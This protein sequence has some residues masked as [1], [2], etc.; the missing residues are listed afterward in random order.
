MAKSTSTGWDPVLLISQIVAMQTLHYLTLSILIPPLLLIFCRSDVLD[1]VGGA[2]NVGMIMDWRELAGRPT[3]HSAQRSW[4]S[5]N[6]V[7]SGGKQVGSGSHL[8]GHW[9]GLV[10]PRRGW[11]IA[12]CWITASGADIYYLYTLIRRP[13]MI[14]DF[15]LTLIFNHLVLT[16]YYAASFPTT[17]F[18]WGVVIISAAMMVIVAEQLCVKRE[19]TE[20]LTVAA[21]TEDEDVEMGSLLRRD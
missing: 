18:F 15:S 16:T 6:S 2:A 13:R 4:G 14:L 10:D 20:G 11:I 1:Y 9:D 21:P 17:L 8:D 19:M 5:W 3:I 12:A 7:W